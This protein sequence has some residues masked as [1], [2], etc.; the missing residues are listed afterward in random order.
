MNRTKMSA[1]PR[2]GAR[3]NRRPAGSARAALSFVKDSEG[4]TA[5]PLDELTVAATAE[6][7][8]SVT[9]GAGAEYFRGRNAGTTVFTVGGAPGTHTVRLLDAR[10]KR[11]DSI[12]FTMEAKTRVEDGTGAAKQT[13]DIL[14]HTMRCYGPSGV[15]EITWRGGSRLPCRNQSRIRHISPPACSTKNPASFPCRPR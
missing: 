13:F 6:G 12:T 10:G 2:A 14:N 11:L 3:K 8:I 1:V 5:Q 7:D 15:H 9:D 4:W